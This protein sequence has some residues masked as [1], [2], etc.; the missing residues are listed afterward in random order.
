MLSTPISELAPKCII[1]AET[2]SPSFTAPCGHRYC[3]IC[4]E[5]YVTVSI[6]DESSFPPQCCR[7]P[8]PLDLELKEPSSSRLSPSSLSSVL[9]NPA[10]IRCLK[11][12]AHEFSVPSGDRL[13]CPNLQCSVF[14]GSFNALR[15]E[16]R[17]VPITCSSCGAT[18]CPQCKGVSHTGLKCPASPELAESQFRKLVKEKKWQTCPQCREIVER[19]EGCPHMVCRCKA[20]FCYGC[21]SNWDEGMGCICGPPRVPSPLLRYWD[22][23]D[24]DNP[25]LD[26]DSD[27]DD[28]VDSEDGLGLNTIPAVNGAGS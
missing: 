19:T 15:I 10:L 7:Q 28:D 2:V 6:K 4:L 20:E 12:K 22:L 27:L 23:D 24:D 5:N 25:D 21:G 14:L 3:Q 18:V 1:C 16:A 8:F 9:S 13:Y 17:P 26:D 11:E